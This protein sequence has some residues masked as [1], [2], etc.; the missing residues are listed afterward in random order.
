V[1]DARG[2]MVDAVGKVTRKDFVNEIDSLGVLNITM[3]S[4]GCIFL[5]D[6]VVVHR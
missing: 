3:V 4:K 2:V 6:F 5:K 1:G